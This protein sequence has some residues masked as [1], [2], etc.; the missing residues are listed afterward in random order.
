MAI[1]VPPFNAQERDIDLLLLE[2]M[3]CS[4]EFVSWIGQRAGIDDAKLIMAQHSV[5]KRNGETDVLAVFESPAGRVALM[6]EDK[7]GAAMQPKQAERY[8]LRGEQICA[9]EQNI[10][11]YRTLLCAPKSYLASVPVA[12]WHATLS[13]EDIAEWFAKQSNLRADWRRD[14]LMHAIRRQR[15]STSGLDG[16]GSVISSNLVDF[17]SHYHQHINKN[18]PDFRSSPQPGGT[19]EFHLYGIDFPPY[20]SLKHSFT[21]SQIVIIFEK[22]WKEAAIAVIKEN[23]LAEGMWLTLHPSA[24]YLVVGVEPIDLDEPFSNQVDLVD[25]AIDAARGLLPYAMMVQQAPAPA[26]APSSFADQENSD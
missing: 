6:I 5:Y 4:P 11:R 13:L 20:I 3:H 2:E 25:L 15:R 23:E 17:K 22:K 18:Y 7:I 8:H 21:Q 1:N 14:V 19:K 9:A 26:A 24:L 12:D 10:K 16:A